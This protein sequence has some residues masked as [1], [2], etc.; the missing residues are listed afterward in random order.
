MNRMKDIINKFINK[1]LFDEDGNKIFIKSNKGVLMEEIKTFENHHSIKLPFELREILKIS[2]GINLYG[3]HILSLNEIEVLDDIGLI[4]FHNW[5]NGDFDYI[6][7]GKITDEGTIIIRLH[8]S[9]EFYFVSSSLYDWFVDTIK[10]IEKYGTLYHPSDFDE[11][12]SSLLYGNLIK[13]NEIFVMK[14]NSNIKEYNSNNNIEKIIVSKKSF[15]DIELLFYDNIVNI[16]DSKISIALGCSIYSD[17]LKIL[18]DSIKKD[19][20]ISTISTNEIKEFIINNSELIIEFVQSIFKN[21]K[22]LYIA[23]GATI[24]YAIYLYLLKSD[25]EIILFKVINEDNA[26]MKILQKTK[27]EM[28]L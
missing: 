2:N 14:N 8:D 10:E 16:I 9:N 28:N 18:L 17:D 21:S 5:G 27:N 3:L 22:T 4:S 7:T 24:T 13:C 15:I 6:S 19:V 23:I 25:N 1:P 20:T 11:F 12:N 26:F